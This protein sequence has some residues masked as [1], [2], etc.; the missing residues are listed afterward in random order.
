MNSKSRRFLLYIL[1]M[2]MVVTQVA[3]VKTGEN[4]T[5]DESVVLNTNST[6][7]T[8]N[9]TDEGILVDNT[10]ALQDELA[11]VVTEEATALN[12]EE[13]QAE[14]SEVSR[15]VVVS[16]Q[17]I[18]TAD[19]L[20]DNADPEAVQS[21]SNE[22]YF[23]VEAN[24]EVSEYQD[25]IVSYADPYL[26]VRTEATRDSSTVGKLFPGS[27]ADIVERGDE[28]TKIKSGNVEGY[29]Q[30][31]Y[32]CFD[33]EAEDLADQLGGTLSTAM[34]LAEEK[35]AA[36]EAAKKAAA[37]KN[38][39][40]TAAMSASSYEVCL[41]A[42]IIDWEA[43]AE[44]YEGKVAVGRVVLNRVASPRFGNSVQEVLSARG[45]FGG[46]TDG[47]GNW[48]S[49][50]QDRI[51]K[52]VNGASNDC[53]KAAQDALAGANPLDATYYYFNTVVGSCSQWQQIGHHTFYN[54]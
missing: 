28:W 46:V 36:E 48:S 34:T 9:A 32:V 52:Y 2:A 4:N 54:Y 35:K 21:E 16:T 41:L 18:E 5:S 26:P 10:Q 17:N 23:G 49:R 37:S 31:I 45:Q 51:N 19:G 33:D 38:N 47:Y 24:A 3:F 50:F 1:L 15:M 40:T 11:E 44:P 8:E 12:V 39:G 29:I 20:V 27:Y 43:N 30:N 42:A 22:S 7:V 14:D 6:D 25:M 13:Q 53:L